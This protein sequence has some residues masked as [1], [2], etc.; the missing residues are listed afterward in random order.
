MVKSRS[1]VE[2]AE[3]NILAGS[4]SNATWR[5]RST[6]SLCLGG[7]ALPNGTLGF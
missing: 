5:R 2:D 1:R 3:A 7:A 4:L 6:A